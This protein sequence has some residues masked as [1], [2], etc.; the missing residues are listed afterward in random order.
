MSCSHQRI[1]QEVPLLPVRRLQEGV[2]FGRPPAYFGR[3]GSE[4]GVTH[5]L[6]HLLEGVVP[7]AQTVEQHSD[8]RKRAAPTDMM[9][10]SLNRHDELVQFSSNSCN[11]TDTNGDVHQ[12]AK[13][14]EP[15]HVASR[16]R[17]RTSGSKTEVRPARTGVGRN[18][19]SFPRCF[20]PPSGSRSSLCVVDHAV[21][22][23]NAPLT[24]LSPASHPSLH[25][26]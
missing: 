23:R 14:T 17:Q 16:K 13:L 18:P 15:G 9:R 10:Q 1:S 22:S 3:M 11:V 24:F 26:K 2:V 19:F 7:R 4:G 8:T 20:V 21:E 25:T 5:P 12:Q 6:S